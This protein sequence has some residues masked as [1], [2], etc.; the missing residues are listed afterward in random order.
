MEIIEE[1]SGLE[2]CC[3]TRIMAKGEHMFHWHENY[4]ICRPLN[5]PCR[6]RIDGEIVSAQPKDIVIISE[7]TVHQFLIDSDETEVQIIQFHPRI[8]FAASEKVSPLM[9]HIPYEVIK[10]KEA[11]DERIEAIVQLM[12][13][14]DT[15]DKADKNSYFQSLSS[16]L[17]FLL[18]KYFKAEDAQDNANAKNDFYK[19]VNYLNEHLCESISVSSVAERF[20]FSRARLSFV[21]RKFAGMSVIEYVNLGRI[22][23]VNA[24]LK[25]GA[26]ITEAALES[27]F[28]SIRTFNGV[29]KKV[30][31]MT[32]R[33]YLGLAKQQDM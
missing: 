33:E 27:G 28:E 20:Y 6:F 11:L 13:S 1:R 8:L 17:Y 25:G 10:G 21:F 3:H 7:Q 31:G 2:L 30:M 29:Y 24:L 14:E 19:V 4:E 15:A 22:K 26:S 18:L 16:A 12:E 5:K 9:K 23:R 32:P